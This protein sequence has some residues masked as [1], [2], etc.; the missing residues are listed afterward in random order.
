VLDVLLQSRRDKE[1]AER[2]RRKLLNEQMRPP[3]VMI[4]DTLASYGAA[5]KNLLPGLAHCHHKALNNRA[6]NSHQPT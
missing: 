4:T 3:R 5:R 1:A 2:L 6:E